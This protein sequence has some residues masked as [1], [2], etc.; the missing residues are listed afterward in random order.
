MVLNT[1]TDRANERGRERRYIPRDVQL[2]D[3]YVIMP[4]MTSFQIGL[5]VELQKFEITPF[6]FYGLLRARY[7]TAPVPNTGV[8]FL[9]LGTIVLERV[10]NY[11]VANL[12]HLDANLRFQRD[13]ANRV[14][15]VSFVVQSALGTIELHQ[16]LNTAMIPATA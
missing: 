1:K 15:G 10:E 9:D 4:Q 12:S 8:R 13:S 14:N 2:H 11:L 3:L 5:V 16:V 7:N 6:T